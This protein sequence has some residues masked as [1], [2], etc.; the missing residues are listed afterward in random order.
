MTLKTLVPGILLWALIGAAG[1]SSSPSGPEKQKTVKVIGQVKYKGSPVA[2]ATVVFMAV[3]GKVSSHGN[4]DAAGLFSLSTY[5]TEDGAPP[6]RY[7]VIVTA[8]TAREVEPGV[9]ADE[10]PGGFKSPVPAKYANPSTTDL[11]VMVKEEGTNDL[12]IELK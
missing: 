4:T 10:P 2:N 8:V 6:G 9:L 12:T 7:R 11:V 1:C 3:D 5:G